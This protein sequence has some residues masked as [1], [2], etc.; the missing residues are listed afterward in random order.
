MNIIVNAAEA[1]D[2][3]G[4]LTIKTSLDTRN[5]CLKI[6]FADTGHGIKQEDKERLFEPFFT[7]KEVGKGTGLGLAIS[8]SIVQKHQGSIKVESEIG[9]GSTFTVILPWKRNLL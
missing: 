8:Y 9:K 4:V 1:M 2:E 5:E 3:N 6:E 7:T